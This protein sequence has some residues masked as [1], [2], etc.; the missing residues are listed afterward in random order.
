VHEQQ[1]MRIWPMSVQIAMTAS[2][3]LAQFSFLRAQVRSQRAR[4][5]RRL[6]SSGSARETTLPLKVCYPQSGSDGARPGPGDIGEVLL[7][8][9][10]RFSW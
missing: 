5:T 7:V 9:R 4:L 3:L 10:Q 2:R 8:V 1:G 6:R